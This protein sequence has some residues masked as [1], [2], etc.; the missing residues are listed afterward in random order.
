MKYLLVL[1]NISSVY[2]L[3]DWYYGH[4][5][6][7]PHQC[8]DLVAQELGVSL[9][10]IQYMNFD[11]DLN[12][13]SDLNIYNVPLSTKPLKF[14]TWT[15]DCPPR[16][17]LE[18]HRT[19]TSSDSEVSKAHQKT[20]DAK[21]VPSPSSSADA[22]E[23]RPTGS[24]A[25]SIADPSKTL[26]D[27]SAATSSA[28]RHGASQTQKKRTSDLGQSEAD[29]T[30][31]QTT[32]SDYPTTTGTAKDREVTKE[33][34]ALISTT[35][36]KAKTE[37]RTRS[38]T[39]SFSKTETTKKDAKPT[40]SDGSTS[41]KSGE[42]SAT[43]V[44]TSRPS[45]TTGGASATTSEGKTK[46]ATTSNTVKDGSSMSRAETEATTRTDTAKVTTL[47]TV[48]TSTTKTAPK[49]TITDGSP[50]A[51]THKCGLAKDYPGHADAKYAEVKDKAVD[52]CG[53][54]EVR[55]AIMSAESK[56]IKA[57]MKG[58]RGVLESLFR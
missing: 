23:T 54:D 57:V 24:I 17:V 48:R 13:I 26:D 31:P 19:C 37:T 18:K 35:D 20:A 12:I 25:T 38:N 39:G 55:G 47:T 4:W 50:H 6:P 16:L 41:M 36:V 53:K 43:A 34:T 40:T 7:K 52:W 46:Q 3:C 45:K 27:A 22:T 44:G 5:Q 32:H 2:G 11:K 21:T 10:L 51:R 30:S 14:A 29:M 33:T 42:R 8:F 58:S 1:L 9:E 28:E 15:D 56:K 49:A